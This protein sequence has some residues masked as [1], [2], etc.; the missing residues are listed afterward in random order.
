MKPKE[1]M[2]PGD[3]VTYCG[4]TDGPYFPAEHTGV[5]EHIGERRATVRYQWGLHYLR[6]DCIR[7]VE[8]DVQRAA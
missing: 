5:L 8:A 1:T 3:F 4:P 6:L 7:L 2:K